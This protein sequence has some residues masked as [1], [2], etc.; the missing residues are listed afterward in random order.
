LKKVLC[1]YY[2]F[3]PLVAGWWVGLGRIK[4]MPEFGWQP[5]VVS[6]AESVSYA[7]DYSLLK[8][9]PDSIEVHRVGHPEPSR[10]LT[11]ARQKL[12]LN[13]IFPDQYQRWYYPALREARK[14]LQREKVDL[15][16]SV[17]APYTCHFIAKKLKEEFNI[18]WVTEWGDP[19]VE[20]EFLKVHYDNT[21]M[22]PLRQFQKLLFRKGERDIL[23]TADKSIVDCEPHQRQLFEDYGFTDDKIGLITD[24]G[25]DE[26]DFTDL[27]LL[28]LY[29]DKL[30]ITFLG[31]VYPD[32]MEP[33]RDFLNSVNQVEK[34][35]EIVFIGRGAV[36]LQGMN[37]ANLTCVL[38]MAR[39]K[40]L[41]FAAGGDFLFIVMPPYARW[42]PGKLWEYLRLGR[43]ILALVP[44]DGDPGKIIKKAKGGFILSHD[45]EEMKR[46]LKDI[47]SQWR[48]GK[49][50]D[51][52]PDWE[53]IAQFERRNLTRKLVTIFDK[54]TG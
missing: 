22:K 8:T 26:S 5:I 49:L 35:A 41:A 53:Y 30:A 34:D 19:W 36:A 14:I 2:F 13:F 39:E 25:Y 6:A 20:N 7:K 17:S 51:F 10:E 46:Q 45:P 11:F 21:L 9:M 47:F 31:S 52:H 50:K 18:P 3:P 1:I 44:E 32:F 12:K 43:P 40:A 29:P 54:V 37:V 24:S 16:Y 48:E 33:I 23:R 42:I 4:F 15:I 28:S 27:K 38:H